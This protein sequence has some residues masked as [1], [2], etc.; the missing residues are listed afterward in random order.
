MLA[1]L[2]CADSGVKVYAF[3]RFLQSVQIYTSYIV[4][5]FIASYGFFYLHYSTLLHLS[6]RRCHFCR[7]TLG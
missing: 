2:R 5:L 7:K 4:S 6:A 3:T 1:L